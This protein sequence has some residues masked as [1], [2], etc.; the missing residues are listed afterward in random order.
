MTSEVATDQ[1]FE[2]QRAHRLLRVG[3]IDEAIELLKSIWDDTHW[4]EALLLL[5]SAYLE[6]REWDLAIDTANR[7][8]SLHPNFSQA[9][10]IRAQGLLGRGS[11]RALAA[12]ERA[13]ALAPDDP[14][15]LRVL[16]EAQARKRDKKQARATVERA[17]ALDPTSASSHF[18][19]AVL[20]SRQKKWSDAELHYRA[21]LSIEP[22]NWVAINNLAVSVQKQ[23]RDREANELFRQAAHVAPTRQLVTRNLFI[24][25]NRRLGLK[26]TGRRY[27]IA[28]FVVVLAVAAVL[29]S[30]GNGSIAGWEFPALG[31]VLLISFVGIPLVVAYRARRLTPDVSRFHRYEWR[32]WPRRRKRLIL[33]AIAL[34]VFAVT[35]VLVAVRPALPAGTPPPGKIWFGSNFGRNSETLFVID[36]KSVF[37]TRDQI[38]WV[39]YFSQDAGANEFTFELYSVKSG[40]NTTL[41]RRFISVQNTVINQMADRY[42]ASHFVATGASHSGEYGI[43]YLRGTQILAVGVFHLSK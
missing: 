25:A 2:L 38:A 14:S 1:A 35:V 16:A 19:A 27:R 11:S 15:D 29:R 41:F 33:A 36:R 21:A 17:L 3:R 42:S 13:V 23:G 8:I 12:A 9:H 10:V 7:L 30:T 4:P 37:R 18:A 39:A 43:E 22:E 6:Q 34:S 28:A 24:S 32:T 5:A 26:Y 40:R 31:L 20:A